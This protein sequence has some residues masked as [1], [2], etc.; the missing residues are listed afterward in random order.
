MTHY[1]VLVIGENIE[2]K[3]APY[4]NIDVPPYIKVPKA[5]VIATRKRL[6][7]KDYET[8]SKILPMSHNEFVEYWY[9]EENVDEHGNVMSTYNPDSKWDWYQLGGRWQGKFKLKDDNMPGLYGKKSFLD[10]SKYEKGWVDSAKVGDI[11]WKTV[12]SQTYKNLHNDWNKAMCN[13]MRE[14]RQY[15]LKV[16]GTRNNYLKKHNVFTT[17]AVITEDGK[18]HAPGEMGWFGISN[19]TDEEKSKWN[20]EYFDRF[21]KNLSPDTTISIVDCHI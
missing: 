3:L 18:W 11:D 14:F 8:R 7:M 1:T 12:F 4:K 21:I 17:Y 2:E 6:E 13:P 5:R 15:Y 20:E 10:E 16:Y 19:E 9:G